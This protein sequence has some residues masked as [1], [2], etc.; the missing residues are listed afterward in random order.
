MKVLSG[1]LGK[2]T[3]RYQAPPHDRLQDEM[4][5]FIAWFNAPCEIDPIIRSALAHFR[6]VTIHPFDDGNGRIGRAIADMALAQ[7]EKSTQRF[8]S[9]SA[10]IQRERKAYYAALERSQKGSLDVTSWLEWYLTC[11]VRAW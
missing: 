8:Y 1:P 9:M 4:Q 7:S 3:V 6:F 5:R 2:E 11:L 10:Q